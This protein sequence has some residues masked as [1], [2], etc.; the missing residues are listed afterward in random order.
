MA[1]WVL[2]PASSFT[3]NRL[4]VAG[5]TSS[6]RSSSVNSVRTHGSFAVRSSLDTNVSDMSVNGNFPFDFLIFWI[7]IYI[8]I[9]W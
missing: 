7:Y 2:L 5:F 6:S 3:G 8:Y 4:E 1:S 9:Y